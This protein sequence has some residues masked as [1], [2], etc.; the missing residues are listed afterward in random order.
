MLK[1]ASEDNEA[2]LLRNGFSHD[3]SRM[4]NTQSPWRIS[5]PLA[6]RC[7]A[8]D[9]SE[10]RTR[11]S[12]RPMA[13]RLL[14]LRFRH[15]AAVTNSLPP[16]VLIL[17]TWHTKRR[18]RIPV[19]FLGFVSKKRKKNILSHTRTSSTEKLGRMFLFFST[20]I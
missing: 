19:Q 2:R 14:P 6:R 7:R 15:S 10:L 20:P 9:Q 11:L 17:F 5:P 8:T 18:S 12:R 16:T 13:H 1:D 3:Y 4:P